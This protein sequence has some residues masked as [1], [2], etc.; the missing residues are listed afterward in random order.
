MTGPID[1]LDLMRL[2]DG[3]LPPDEAASVEAYLRADP[4]ALATLERFERVGELVRELADKRGA[5]GTTIAD[6]VMASIERDRAARPT[7]PAWR[8]I[9]PIGAAVLA[10]AAAAALVVRANAPHERPASRVVAVAHLPAAQPVPASASVPPGAVAPEA[11]EAVPSVAIESVDFG[12][13]DGTIFM[14]QNG[15]SETPVVWLMDDS[16]VPGGRI[17]PL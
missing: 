6:S 2:H 11:E 5:G 13:R 8:R 1:D 14:V 17:E 9:A 15:E 4:Q 16:A 12:A 7:M 3:E 10:M